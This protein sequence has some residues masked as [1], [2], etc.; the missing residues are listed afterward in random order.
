MQ[1]NKLHRLAILLSLAAFAAC[2]A[3]EASESPRF[4]P[5]WESLDQR[6]CPDWYLDSK[7]G[8]FIHW[9]VYSVPAWGAPKQYA[10]WYW[11][12]MAEEIPDGPLWSR[13]WFLDHQRGCKHCAGRFGK[14]GEKNLWWEHHTRFWGQDFDYTGFAPLFKCEHFDPDQWADV[15]VRSGA[16]YIVLTSKHHDGFC[17]WPSVDADRTWG[18]PW[19][20]YTTGPGRDLLGDLAA[21]CRARAL[22]F[23]IYYSLYEWFNPLWLANR[24]TYIDNHMIPQF[25]DVVTRYRPDIIFSDGEW[26][27]PYK[28]WKSEELVAWLFNESPSRDD[29]VINDRWGNNTRHRHGTYFTTEYTAG[30]QAAAH[31]WEESRGMGHSYGYNRA[32]TA[33]D[34]KSARELIL[35]LVDLVSRGGNLLLDVGPTSDG[36]IPAI[37]QDRLLEIGRWLEVNGEAIHGS[38][39]A[40]RDCQWTS[41]RR[42]DQQYGTWNIKYELMDHVGNEPRGDQAVKQIFFTRKADALYA[43]TPGWPGPRLVVHNVRIPENASITLLGRPGNLPYVMSG[44][45]LV[46]SLPNLSGHELPCLYAYTFKISGGELILK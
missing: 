24:D 29:L 15:F 35:V 2:A 30:M 8:I 36:R 9:G 12:N 4:Q 31:P 14:E 17:L 13:Q 6:A 39:H 22:K 11:H 16:K 20:S 19:N 42:P 46:I 21:A 26:D 37:M 1:V 3:A 7:F 34:Y 23:G 18:R 10:E 41:G 44:D 43:I 40:G 5:N 25:K 27:L 33:D 45:T 38:R 28:I 32:E